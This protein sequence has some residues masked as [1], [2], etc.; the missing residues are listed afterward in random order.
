M[1]NDTYPVIKKAF[2]NFIK[3]NF[4]WKLSFPT[5]LFAVT[6]RSE[7]AERTELDVKRKTPKS[8]DSNPLDYYFWNALKVKVYEGLPKPFTSIEQLKRRVKRVWALLSTKSECRNRCFSS[9]RDWVLLWTPKEAQLITNLDNHSCQLSLA[10]VCVYCTGLKLSSTSKISLFHSF[11]RSYYPFW[12]K[13]FG[14][15]FSKN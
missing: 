13:M 12:R 5:R 6:T 2:A 7:Q 4:P 9:R 1:L 11:P 3:R 10:C 8:P 14:G 15:I